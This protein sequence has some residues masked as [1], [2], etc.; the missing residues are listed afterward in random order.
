MVK[1]QLREVEK[2]LRWIAKRNR[3][4]S[5]SI[6]LVLLYVMLGMNAF[7]QGVH[8]TVATKQEIGLSTD[9]LSEMLRRI[10]EENSKK[11]KGTQLEL[12]QLM[13]Q[14]DQVVKSPWSSW[15]FGLNYLYNNWSKA[16]KGRGDKSEKYL[17]EEIF[18]RSNNFYER[19]VS[20]LSDQYSSFSINSNATSA[21]SNNRNGLISGYGLVRVKQVEEP[22]VD[23]DVSAGVRPKQVVK[24]TITIADK[25]PVTPTQ[26]EAIE[27]NT[28]SINIIP[29]TAVTITATAPTMTAPTVTAPTVTTPN[30]PT[31]LSFSPVTPSVTAPIQPKIT[32]SNPPDLTFNGTGFGQGT[33]YVTNQSGL[34]LENYHT[35]NTTTPIH[36]KY[37]ANNRIMTGGPVVVTKNDGTPGT[38]LNAGNSTS[39]GIY[40]I[41]DA[42][43]HSVTINGDYEIT[44]ESDLG[45][46][47]LYF[48]SLNPYEVGH[49]SSTD[50]VYHFAGNLKLHGHNNPSSE[51]LLLGFEHQLLANDGG[52]H[53]HYLNVENGTVTSILKNTGTITLQSGYNLVG[54][55]IDT[56][57]TPSSNGYFK[58]QP[59]TINDGTI[60]IN[61][62]R[63]IGIDYGNYFNA[64]PNTRLTLGNIE[65]NGENNY[66][67]RMRSYYNMKNGGTT[68]TYYD[69]TD[70]TGGGDTKKISVQGKNN[71]G[72]SIA[73][74]KSSGDPL[75]KITKL[76][77]EVGGTNNVG[78]LRNSQNALPAANV[79]QS[80]MVLN[81]TTIGNTFN[82]D[83]SATGGALIRSDIYEVK[84]DKDI[85]VGATGIQNSLM[86]AGKDGK[87]TLAS[88]KTI[89]STVSDEFYGMT[90]GNFETTADNKEAV[91]TNKGTLN[92]GGKKSLGMAIDVDDKG[93][94]NGKINFSGTNGAGVYNTGTFTAENSSEINVSG[95][96]SIGA[97]NSKTLTIANGAKITGTAEDSTGIY[98][99]AGTATNNGTIS[100]NGTSVKGLVV[101]GAGANITNNKIVTVT[102]KEAVA[103]AALEGTITA[104]GGSIT[105]DGTSGIALYAGGTVGGTIEATGGTVEAKNGAI[106]VYADKGTIKFSGATVKTE[107]SSLAFMQSSNGGT[108]D[109][110]SATTADI[111]TNGTAFYIPPA[112]TPSTVTYTPFTGISS[113]TGFNNLNNLTLNMSPNSNLAV[114]SFVRSNVSDLGSA[115]LGSLGANILGTGYN[116]YLLYKSELTANAGTTYADFKKIALSNSS[117][118][119]DTTLSTTD[120]NV[121]L[122]AQEN[123]ETDKDWVK[124]INNATIELKGTNSLAMYASNGKI[125]NAAGASI[126]VGNTG[127]AI[128]GSNKG[129]GDTDIENS[130]NITVGESSTAIYAKD[131]KTTGLKNNGTIT[132]AGDKGIGMSYVS[133]L[134][135]ST[136]V[137]NEGTISGTA[138]KGTGMYVAKDANSVRYTALNSNKI[139]LGASGVGIYTNATSTGTNSLENTGTITVGDNGIG[140]Y[141]FEEKT[142]GNVTAGKSGIA[143]YSQGGIVSIGS[144][145]ESPTITVGNTKA[146]AVFTTGSGQTITSTNAK[147]NIGATSYGFVNTGSGNTLNI[148]G[149]VAT[150]TGN[151]VFIYSSDTTGNITNAT[152][153]T[154]TGSIGS[155]FGVYSAGTV[156]N[157]GNITLT[158]GTGNVGVYAINN[159]NITNSGTITLGASTTA[160]RSIGAIANTGTVTN[161]GNIVVNGQYGIGTYSTGNSTINNSGDIT[162]T[163]DETIGNYGASGSNMNVSSGTVTLTGNKSTGYYLDGGTGSTIASG[164]KIDVSGNEAS[165]VYVNNNG[166]LAY[167]GATTV[168][169]DA[170]YGFIVDGNST[171]TATGGTLT[172]NGTS[173]MNG[174]S[175][176]ANANRGSAA[177]VVT[178]GS[179][180]TGN[181][182]D[183]TADIAGENSVGVYSAGN[184]AIDSANISAYDSGV[185]FFTAGGTISIGNN[186]GTSTV[187]TGT[188]TN[189]G[190]LLFYTPTGSILLKGPVNATVQGSTDTIKRGTAFYYTGG[191]TLGIISSYTPLNPT[192]IATWARSS[193]GNGGTS[194]LGNL[195][196]TMNQDS[197]LFLTERVNMELSNTS[198][199]N[200]FSGL[201]ASERPHITGSNFRT[202]MLYHSHLN[203][204]QAVNLDNAN[205]EYNLMEISSSAITNNNTITGTQA[206]QI[207]MAQENDTTTKAVVTLTNHGTIDLSGLNSAGIYGKNAIIHN[208]NKITVGNSSSGI[209]GLN[210]TEISNTGNITTGA[211]STAIYY[212]DVEKDSAGNITAVKNTTTG[213]KNAGTIVL[214]GDDSVGLTYEPG[215]ISGTVTFENTA[216]ITSSGDKNVGM[217]AK[218]AQNGASYDTINQG[219]I[220][221][222]NSASLS[223]PNVAMYT[224][225]TSIGSN[226]LKNMGNITV[227]DYSVA[228]YGFEENSSGNIKV[229]NGSIGL[230]SKNGNVNVSGS[231][232]TGSS[233][234]SVG[235]YTV[236]SGQT[237]TSTGSTFNLG[238]TSFG[239]VN[240]GNNTI[241]STGGSATLS[242]NATFIYSSDETSHITNSTNISSSGAIGRNYG[243]YA[244]GIVDNSGNIDFGSGVG[245]LGIYMVKGGKGTN[246]ATITV[247]ASD[248]TNELFGV[249]MA[250]GYIGDATTAPTTGTVENQGT[251]NVNGPYSIGMY[252]AKTGTIVTNK[253]DIILNASNTT[254]IYVEEGA[255]AINDGTIKTGASGLSNVNGVVLG[256]G[257]TLENNGT[258]N[259]AATASNG[260]L[261][262]GG[263]IAN[264]GSI[265]VS[266]SGS[267]ETKLLN[268]TPTSKGI[269][270]VVIEAPAG[271]TTATITAGGVV[272]TP[273]IVSTTARNPISVSAD[274]IGLYV[275]TSG[276]DFT[277]SI[278]GLGHLTSQADLIIGTE[279]AASTIS[280]YIQIKDN[281]ILDPYNN[282]ILSSGVSKWNVYSGSLG[283]ITTPTLDPG[284]GK[285]TNLYMAKIPYT[286]WSKNQDTYNFTDGLE[287]RY[288]VEELETRENQL[289]QKLNSIGNNEE[290]LLYQAFDEMMGHQYAN[291]QQRIQ[292]TASI[293]DK[294]LKYLKKEWDTKSKDS[295]K[296]KAFGMR[297][298]YKT[299][300]AGVMDYSSHAQ[301]FAY[302]HE[303]ETVQLG[304]TTG[305]YAGLIHHEFKFKDIGKSKEEMLQAKWGVFKSTAFDHNNSL[306]WTISGEM[307]V[308]RNR[309]HRRYLVVDEIFHA[310]SRYWT[311]GLALTNEVSKTFRTSEST[312]VKPYG[313]LKVEYGRFQKIKEKNGEVRLEVKANDYYSVKPEIGVEAG[314]KHDLSTRGAL[315]ARVGVAYSNELGRVAKGKNQA[316]VA[317]TNADWF[318]IRGEKEDRRGSLS[319]DLNLGLENERYGIT[320]NIGYDSKGK[321]KRAGLGLRVIF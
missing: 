307:F 75:S 29:P 66:G 249:G 108:V 179:S 292:A 266:G 50:G 19:Y 251:I 55:Q 202:F 118:I 255:K 100:M 196:L 303:K 139:S 320:A 274:S 38:Q 120:S 222:G 10:K 297:G 42:A 174:T 306:N 278:T 229:G 51:N 54:I 30:L 308:G 43:D 137:E 47:T 215:N 17:Y 14:G 281:K 148:A 122:M 291:V 48:V 261:L 263:T 299:D 68:T 234:E 111:A 275:N 57:Y 221:L 168:S 176:S 12:V 2:N 107:A 13:E 258:I 163:G 77:V 35:Y 240:I 138:S 204:N 104:A 93:I 236:G 126:T 5:F 157:T 314:Y 117:I 186:G 3:N 184:L 180:L 132:L 9:R 192:N 105:A 152:A 190:A 142:T 230:Y 136:T 87:V 121:N 61:S 90:A 53:S 270:S 309:M 290:V 101:G 256:S 7:A 112:T 25:N 282:A 45:N 20:P 188:G 203:V 259:I 129:S 78:F 76:N 214:N 151:G 22:I 243:I 103:A 223:N 58:K 211:S 88:G 62:K 147:Y 81:D 167:S 67:F 49:N 70:I 257:S 185:N 74:G 316:R 162:L 225:A 146:T 228:M 34:Y 273:T 269:G 158:H 86:Q 95:K 160:T 24:G 300:T 144:V 279:A 288:G 92:I 141:G 106:N 177:L 85:T 247:G 296:I 244:S 187:I 21:S 280:K 127:V 201:S 317:Y 262:K 253:H 16:Y 286:E 310:K 130:G 56:E 63:S 313:E 232:T 1:N 289:F 115:S 64:S 200:L 224:N 217:F 28:P 82:F 6:G 99:T 189:K 165:G 169:G 73:Q 242:N 248:V 321:N 171:V 311:Y 198:A 18:T 173:G 155:N 46:G 153:I 89:T 133:K 318:H 15:Q 210:N 260:V 33:S 183:V 208:A 145:S 245:N 250:A 79:N 212:S 194:T 156:T 178:S 276:K 219:S 80:T 235:V 59:Q 60:I 164:A 4:I 114:A 233:K 154:S 97:Y 298:E 32:I 181:N 119:N 166:S 39:Q 267:E 277:S 65:V 23:F 27:F 305:W 26:P 41:S 207:A 302:L 172:I 123:T 109:F 254:G 294:E 125:K 312:F 124:L 272:V 264:Y 191:G 116:D 227:G 199:I 237:I 128:Y 301:G 94:N 150:L 213:L 91:A 149:G 271:A 40:F 220:T 287:Q 216:D 31:T 69:L 36:L 241:T 96:S 295:N 268:S 44:R 265:T 238:D 239:F 218:R 195:N 159:G 84:L 71:V 110:S 193:Y 11:L 197:R 113:I 37:G 319:T 102:G 83:S 246:T 131:Y 72:I 284:T 175:S 143:L 226:P 209:Y 135:S 252:G 285:V 304:N 161:D 283:W 134:S 8:A 52:G 170:A 231:I 315:T 98:A 182:L 140:L 205:D 206:G 293:L